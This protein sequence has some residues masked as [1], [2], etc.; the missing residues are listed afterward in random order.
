MVPD[1]SGVQAGNQKL[2][3]PGVSGALQLHTGLTW[4]VTA[5]PG[6]MKSGCLEAGPRQPPRVAEAA[7]H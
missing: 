5:T 2:R 7:D 3:R 4:A 6:P 1:R